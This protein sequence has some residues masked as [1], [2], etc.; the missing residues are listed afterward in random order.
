MVW[1]LLLTTILIFQLFL[2]AFV[3]DSEVQCLKGHSSWVFWRW[4]EGFYSHVRRSLLKWQNCSVGVE[5]CIN[6]LNFG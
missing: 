6:Y 1:R 3:K 4:E 2:Q 5:R